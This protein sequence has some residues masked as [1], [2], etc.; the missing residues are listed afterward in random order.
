MAAGWLCRTTSFLLYF[1]LWIN[2]KGAPALPA[3]AG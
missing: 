3:P 2:Y 1:S